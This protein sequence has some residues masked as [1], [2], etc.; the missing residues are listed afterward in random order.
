MK[1]T[2][3]SFQQKYNRIQ[4]WLVGQTKL[5]IYLIRPCPLYLF[6]LD[7]LCGRK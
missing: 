6:I 1:L 3:K 4:R 5:F 7:C 2:K